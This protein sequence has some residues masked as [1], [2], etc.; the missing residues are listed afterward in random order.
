MKYIP[1][2]GDE[3]NILLD[4]GLSMLDINMLTN[5]Q[6]V[7]IIQRQNERVFFDELVEKMYSERRQNANNKRTIA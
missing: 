3:Y 5:P 6:V 2:I 1:S 7:L 4:C